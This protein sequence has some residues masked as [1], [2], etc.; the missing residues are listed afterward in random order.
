MM[1]WAGNVARMG[2]PR[3]AYNILI[4]KTEGKR[5]FGRPRSDRG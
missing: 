2:E 3:N 5:L 4:G 1:E